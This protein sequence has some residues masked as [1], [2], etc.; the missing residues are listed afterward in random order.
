MKHYL[1]PLTKEETK[2]AANKGYKYCL[3]N[4]S[5]WVDIEAT[6]ESHDTY[7][8]GTT[9]MVYKNIVYYIHRDF[10]SVDEGFRVYVGCNFDLD[11][12]RIE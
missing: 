2:I 1:F 11:T 4:R 8:R 5:R 9:Y 7:D 3:A 6:H 10:T 12:D